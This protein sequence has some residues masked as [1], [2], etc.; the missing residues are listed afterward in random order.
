DIASPCPQIVATWI[1]HR[2]QYPPK[3][4]DV[5]SY[6]PGI[7]T[8]QSDNT[9]PYRVPLP[10]PQTALWDVVGRQATPGDRFCAHGSRGLVTR[11]YAWLAITSSCL[12]SAS[13]V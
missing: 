12:S 6:L 11:L 5:P 8:P 2:R 10:C 9:A 7:S 1:A 13:V 4:P 3:T